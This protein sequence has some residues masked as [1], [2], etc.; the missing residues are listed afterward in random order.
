MHPRSSS[1]TRSSAPTVF[2]LA[3]TALPLAAG[4]S[5]QRSSV[6]RSDQVRTQIQFHAPEGSTIVLRGA[7]H[8][9]VQL[10]SRGPAGDR[11][12]HSPEEFAVFDVAA[13]RYAFAYAG[14]DGADDAVIYGEIEIHNP[15]SETGRRYRDLSFVPVR[16]PSARAQSGEFLHPS[17]D[18]SYTQGLEGLEFDHLK[19][20]DLLTQ[21]YFVADLAKV[22]H[23]Y[24]V[25]GAASLKDIRRELTVLED[26]RDYLDYRYEQARRRALSRNPDID[27][28]DRVAYDRFDR[29]GREEEYVRLSRK[30]QNLDRERDELLVQRTMLEADR[31]RRNAL[32]RSMN[33]VNRAG[34]MVLATPD[35]SL[36]FHDAVAQASELGEI[37]AVVRVG[38]RHQYWAQHLLGGT[39]PGG[40]AGTRGRTSGD[41]LGR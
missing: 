9:M 28:Q 14:A 35:L 31:D 40:A 23:D 10:R 4:C 33:I 11:L 36:P 12:E 13:G 19:Q 6:R 20:G 25:A 26:R 39:P 18:S 21:V 38:G 8:E 27:I 30:L 22:R 2:I 5:Q 37:V 1:G 32:L 7:D 15:K 29:W 17:R 34:A 24:E 3:A 16:L 41:G